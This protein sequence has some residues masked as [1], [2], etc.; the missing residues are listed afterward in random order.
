MLDVNDRSKPFYVLFAITLKPLNPPLN[1]CKAA[2][3]LFP[4]ACFRCYFW[5]LNF[6][7]WCVLCTRSWSKTKTKVT[8]KTKWS[9][10]KKRNEK[11]NQAYIKIRIWNSLDHRSRAIVFRY[12]VASR[13]KFTKTNVIAIRPGLLEPKKVRMF[14]VH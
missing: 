13:K 4:F 10:K 3:S 12:L 5:D 9:K 2:P 6:N 1:Q 14:K 8:Q 7:L 11:W